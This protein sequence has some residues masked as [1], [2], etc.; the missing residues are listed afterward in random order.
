M[1]YSSAGA[2]ERKFG[3]DQIIYARTDP[4]GIITY[5]GP[6]LCTVS[7]YSVDQIEGASQDVLR[8]PDTPKGIFWMLWQAI[9]SGQ[10]FGTYLKNKAKDGRFYSVFNVIQPANGGYLSAQ[11]LPQGPLHAVATDTYKE[12]LAAE[13]AG[14]TPQES[15]GLIIAALGR[16]GFSSY[17]GFQSAALISEVQ[18]QAS[19]R[20][21][22]PLA[23]TLGHLEKLRAANGRLGDENVQLMGIFTS[24][25]LLPMNMRLLASRLEPSG[26]PITAISDS[27]KRASAEIIG[28]LQALAGGEGK[29]CGLMTARI[30]AAAFGLAS[31]AVY[32]MA[33]AQFIAKSARLPKPTLPDGEAAILSTASARSTARA[34]TAIS[35]VSALVKG[36]RRDG[37]ILLRQMAG[38]DQIRILGQVESGRNSNKDSGLASVM[39]QLAGF[40]AAIHARLDTIL[41][42]TIQLHAITSALV[43]T[44]APQ[45]VISAA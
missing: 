18:A 45:P 23:I 14:A 5:A 26:G 17:A 34:D 36:V 1:S 15:A 4:R 2:E 43:E 32:D 42:L 27:Y 24:L 29:G 41:S 38:L 37:E 13:A 11:V 39:A 25:H 33:A 12:A 6:S 31:A 28:L 30:E 8:H 22:H 40:H 3:P 16:L 44:S 10:P 19:H 9:Q 7:A 35:E 21:D 20:K